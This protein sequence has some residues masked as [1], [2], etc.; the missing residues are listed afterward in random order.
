MPSGGRLPRSSV[1]WTLMVRMPLSLS[2]FLAVV[3][4]DFW[5]LV[6][7]SRG[8]YPVELCGKPKDESATVVRLKQVESAT[9][10]LSFCS[11]QAHQVRNCRVGSSS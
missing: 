3:D 9:G 5:S 2:R 10:D 7:E 1:V 4:A 6:W 8:R 11:R